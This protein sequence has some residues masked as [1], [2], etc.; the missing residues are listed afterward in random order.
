MGSV[1]RTTTY[2]LRGLHI[3]LFLSLLATIL[4]GCTAINLMSAMSDL[5]A[6]QYEQ[7]ISKCEEAL[8]NNKGSNPMM[9]RVAGIRV[10]ADYLSTVCLGASYQ[11]AG[12]Y[13]ESS[14][15]WHESIRIFPEKA[16]FSYLSLAELNYNFGKLEESYEYSRQALDSVNSPSYHLTMKKSI[17][18]KDLWKNAAIAANEFYR[19]RLDSTEMENE[20]EL[21]NY[22]NA[23]LERSGN[24]QLP[25]L[26]EESERPMSSQQLM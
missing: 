16:Y 15:Y 12:D 23:V 20:F 4:T 11:A 25:F 19:L 14:Y 6:G 22:S 1:K 24:I 13:D 8:R 21:G 10:N 17:Y 5:K 9:V 2:C 26:G 18:D 7:A 3:S